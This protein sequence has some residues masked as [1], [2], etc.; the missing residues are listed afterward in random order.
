M[1]SGDSEISRQVI[2]VDISDRVL[3]V[4]VELKCLSERIDSVLHILGQHR[5]VRYGIAR[6]LS[7]MPEV[8]GAE[9]CIQRGVVGIVL[10]GCLQLLLNLWNSVIVVSVVDSPETINGR[11]SR[12]FAL[13]LRVCVR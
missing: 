12:V 9:Q 3:G 13:T 7:D 5:V 10:D 8:A 6:C 1:N 2:S 4:V 11:S